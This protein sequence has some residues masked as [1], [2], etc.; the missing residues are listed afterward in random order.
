[1]D[2]AIQRLIDNLHDIPAMPN[3]VIKALNL[4]RDPDSSIKDLGDIISYDQSLSIKVLNLVNSAYYGF[5]QQIS[6]ITRALA[7]LGMN[8]AKNIIVA[9]AMKPMFSSEKN[10][11]LWEHAITTAVGCE[12]VAN[13]LKIMDSDEA[14]MIGFMHD[15]GKIILNM[16]NTELL[17]KIKEL[18][19]EGS[20]II[21]AE[22][23][24]FGTN[25]AEVGAE[26]SKKWQLPVLLTNTIKYH[27]NPT[28]STIP[29]ECSLVYVVDKLVQPDFQE[30]QL[31]TDY[32]KI[33]NIKL[34]HPKILRESIINKALILLNELAS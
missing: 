11:E 10:K 24:F 13:Y 15:I 5:A 21:D 8:K 6:S 2:D 16:Q 28:A 3:V 9:S 33:L 30:E 23:A 4:V 29:T 26:L 25:H 17:A 31:N 20:N 1:M 19:S 7:L 32:V 14:F 12:Y 27:H 34:D 18:T 22:N